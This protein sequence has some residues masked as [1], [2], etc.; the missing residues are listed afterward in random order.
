MPKK[1][2]FLDTNV[3]LECFRINVWSELTQRCQ[4]ETVEMC[5]TE[6]LTGDQTKASFVVVDPEV[7]RKGCYKIHPVKQS[8][9]DLL[10]MADESMFSLDPGELHLF[11]YLHA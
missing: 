9:I 1:R 6:A 5:C 3:I 10:Y 2:V 4:V 7:L 8:D 11:A